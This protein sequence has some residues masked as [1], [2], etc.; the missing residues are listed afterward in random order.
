[1]A[2]IKLGFIGDGRFVCC[3][4]FDLSFYTTPTRII[5]KNSAGAVQGYNF[6]V[7]AVDRDN[8]AK[9]YLRLCAGDGKENSKINKIANDYPGCFQSKR[10]L[11]LGLWYH[12]AVTAREQDG[13]RFCY[14]FLLL[15]LFYYGSYLLTINAGTNVYILCQWQTRFRTQI[16]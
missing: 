9:G 16:Y 2:W 14:I 3:L 1:M 8:A 4:L 7:V 13:V 11:G 12:V 10:Q 15:F 5:D 6:D